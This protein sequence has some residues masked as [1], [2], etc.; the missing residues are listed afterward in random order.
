MSSIPRLLTEA[1]VLAC[2]GPR[3]SLFPSTAPRR[4]TSASLYFPIMRKRV[5]RLFWLWRVSGWLGPSAALLPS[6]ARWWSCSASWCLPILLSCSASWF[7]AASV[8]RCVR[9]SSASLSA[10]A[11][12]RRRSSC[13]KESRI[14]DLGGPST[15]SL[16]SIPRLRYGSASF[17]R[18][19]ASSTD[20]RS[21]REANV[22][23][24][25][26]PNVRSYP[27]TTFSRIFS[28]SSYF[29][30]VFSSVARL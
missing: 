7:T 8:S 17:R 19:I 6:S 5:A 29:C 1:S 15:A 20:A 25:L 23:G 18:P 9:P 26:G 22:S 11:D 16:P 10:K 27:S 12:R 3:A 21:R 2:F 14:L 4:R 30:C 28:A 13:S 24:C